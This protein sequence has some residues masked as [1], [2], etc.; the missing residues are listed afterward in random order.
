[1]VPLRG[2][3]DSALLVPPDGHAGSGDVGT[4]GPERSNNPMNQGIRVERIRTLER[5]RRDL[6]SLLLSTKLDDC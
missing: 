4:C 5:Q 2:S 1:M 3:L 6:P